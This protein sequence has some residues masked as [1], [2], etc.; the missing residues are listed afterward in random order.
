MLKRLACVAIVAMAT[1]GIS[2]RQQPPATEVPHPVR[3]GYTKYEHLVPMRDGVKLFTSVY[4]PKDMPDALSDHAAR[5]RRTAWRRTASTST[6]RRIG[7]SEH[8]MKDGFIFVYQDVRGRYMSE[9]ECV[10]VRPHRPEEDRSGHRREHRHLGHHRLAGEERAVQ[11]R[12]GRHVGH[13]VPGLLR[14]AGMIDAHPALRR[15]RRRRRSPTGTWATTRSTT[16]RSCSAANFSFYAS[17]RGAARAGAARGPARRSTTAR[18]TATSST[19]RWARS[20]GRERALTWP[21][22]AAYYR[23]N[24][25][26][27][28]YDAFWKARDLD[29][30]HGHQAGG[31][32]RRRLVR[33][34]GSSPG[35][36]APIARSRTQ[37]PATDNRLVMGPW[38][39]GGWARGD[40]R[41]ASA[42]STSAAKPRPES[43][44]STSSSRSSRST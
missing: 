22:N 10:E 34:R 7:P 23:D 11:Q 27:P 43:S 29:A 33:R 20:S 44:A 17:F 32:D 36:C 25:E 1:V 26:H 30:L 9:G 14:R 16:A 21:S 15:S 38:T 35:R 6:A 28:T 13:L 3:A 4:V 41:P 12:P 19:C 42:T 5:G 2:A 18:P 37:S 31:A 40:G 39:H 8:F 24:L